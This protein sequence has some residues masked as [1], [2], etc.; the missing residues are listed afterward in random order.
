MIAVG[1][2][3]ADETRRSSARA[4][5]SGAISSRSSCSRPA[6]ETAPPTSC[7]TAR[8]GCWRTST[9]LAGALRRFCAEVGRGRDW[10]AAFAAGFGLTTGA[11]YEEFEGRRV[12]AG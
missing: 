6:A 10:R 1:E 4:V 9:E 7:G 12:N 5:G 2:R 11:F 8:S 3:R